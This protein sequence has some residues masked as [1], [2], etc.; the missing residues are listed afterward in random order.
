MDRNLRDEVNGLHASICKALGDPRRILLL[1]ALTE[2]DRNV[3]QLAEFTGAPQPVVSRH[4]QTLHKQ[5]MV[6]RKRDGTEVI[7]SLADTRVIQALDLLRAF[8]ADRLA[9]QAQLA[10]VL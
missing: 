3:G 2:E 8:L 7:Y 1:Y 6:T 9:A 4:L 10:D 5:G